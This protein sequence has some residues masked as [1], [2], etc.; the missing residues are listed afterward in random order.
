MFYF[1]SIESQRASLLDTREATSTGAKTASKMTENKTD[2]I[3][4]L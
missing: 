4:V 1:L 3:I 2:K